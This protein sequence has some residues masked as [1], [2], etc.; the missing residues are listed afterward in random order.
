VGQFVNCPDPENWYG[1]ACG[2]LPDALTRRCLQ[3][4]T[5][6][7]R[8]GRLL[9]EAVSDVS[10]ENAG[11]ETNWITQLDSARPDWQQRLAHQIA[12]TVQVHTAPRTIPARWPG[13]RLAL[14]AAVL[15]AFCGLTYQF[16]FRK[17]PDAVA[18]RLLAEAATMRRFTDMRLP[19][20]GYAPVGEGM[21]R[22]PSSTFLNNPAPLLKAEALIYDQLA[23]HP[24]NSFWL[25]AK[26][27]AD[28]L[29]GKPDA[30]Q[31][32]LVRALQLSPNSPEILSDLAIAY[33]Q[34]KNFAAAYERLSEVLALKAD[35][36]VALFNRAIVSENQFLYRQA[37]DDWDRYLKADPNS[38][39]AAEARQ[40]ADA[41][42]K[43]LQKSGQQRSTPLLTPAQ[44]VA[45]GEIERHVQINGRLEEYLAHAV[46]DWLPGA[47]PDSVAAGDF[48]RKQALFFLS[49]LNRLEHGDPWLSDLI[50]NSSSHDFSA[51]V[52]ALARAVRANDAGEYTIS[53]E[54]ADRAERLFRA[55]GNRAGVLRAQFEHVFAS[56]ITRD[57]VN[58]RR[59]AQAALADSEKYSYLW[60]T[61]QFELEQGACSFLM[62]D[63]GADEKATAH[64]IGLAHDSP[65]GALYLRG[66]F[67]AADDRHSTGDDQEAMR[68]AE[69]GLATFWSGQFPAVRGYNFYTL[70]AYI[71][72]DRGW[73]HLQ[74]AAWEE[75]TA[76]ADSG[77]DLLL[78]AWAHNSTA[79][80]ATA[81]RRPEVA[82]VQ[83]AEAARL[84]ALVPRTEARGN[85]GVE[86]QI[87]LARL[88]G[89]LGEYDSAIGRL[90]TIQHE[91]RSL[92]NN[93]LS[94]IFYSTLG[95]LQ[96]GKNR[97]PEA[98]Q[99][100]RPALI[101]A[102]Q[103][104]ASLQSEEERTSWSKGSASAYLALIEAQLEQNRVQE[105]LETFEWYL[106]APQRAASK[107]H[108]VSADAMPAPPS[109]SS[110]LPALSKQT[111]LAY[112]VLPGGIAIWV[113][114]DRGIHSQWIPMKTEALR[115][116]VNRFR[117][118]AADRAS[119]LGAIQRDARNLYQELVAPIEQ[120][121]TPGRTLAIEAD[122]FLSLVPY[123]A[124]LNGG[125]HYV[126][127]STPVVYSLGET[128]Q[129]RLRN[130]LP[131]S[132]GMSALIVGST[133]SSS[134]EGL[135]TLPDVTAEADAVSSNFRAA[136]VLKGGQATFR[137]VKA[138]LPEA[139]IFHF[140][141]HSL[142]LP[143]NSG[144]VL[145]PETP[146]GRL[147]LLDAN[148]IR[149]MRLNNMQLA[150]LSAC[151][152]SGE[153]NGAGG[154]KSVTE[155]LLRAG[156]PHVIASRWAVDSAEARFF[157][158]SFYH[159]A[160]AGQ[161]VSE[162][163]RLTQL[164]MLANPRTSH[165]YYWSAFAAYGR[166]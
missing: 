36:P 119:D 60:L 37:L 148:A 46:D 144:L 52:N 102:E 96:L 137:A 112:G 20:S 164:A 68:L 160:L 75:A 44:L 7:V 133:V 9:A 29:D 62:G 159:H 154:F 31:T 24:S 95:E 81:V 121:L 70:Q 77:E 105:S 41:L 123:E 71:A 162:A 26:A 54:Q 90:T 17:S 82:K 23:S 101:L 141:G 115:E 151:S 40:R 51:A 99:A 74:M 73:P 131:I 103:S 110:R 28:L 47:Y 14:A 49:D 18:D 108:T 120:Y 152:T 21:T 97:A 87:R 19:G 94:Q 45:L 116:L 156:V 10:E 61:I 138:E 161:P 63:I 58:C 124:L 114:D 165:P 140:A 130:D 93:W 3:H 78:R 42:R 149:R 86:T 25:H 84:F 33:Y 107:N 129:E 145:A 79:D 92:S 56:Q 166:P 109:L 8:C 113:F 66:A 38:E 34:Q 117:D 136:L 67:F 135:T 43:Q 80:A 146:S 153:K 100:L 69:T 98:E 128:S 22:E 158:D 91:V 106:A 104:L 122:G 163:T 55:S 155:T 89:Q 27:R 11:G 5:D 59:Q 53:F 64:A 111:V 134:S 39:W 118:S 30:A 57:S 50:T 15:V 13:L 127:E 83:Y 48:E 157:M 88:E 76:L 65:Y 32:T 139:A 125:G 6:C 2:Q 72:G 150:V 4:A 12:G 16:G 126:I 147:A 35:D 142:A 143:D 132:S 1:V 85:Y